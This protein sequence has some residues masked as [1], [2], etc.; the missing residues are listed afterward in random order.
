MN[1]E[2]IPLRDLHLPEAVGWW[3]P[4]SGWWLLLALAVAGL[5]LA[6]RA[7]YR[8]HRRNAPRRLALKELARLRRAYRHDGDLA[9]FVVGLSAL[10]RR[11]M[12]A[13]APRQEVAGL[14]GRAWLEWLDR[15][16]DRQPFCEGPGRSLV[17]LPYRDPARDRGGVDVDGLVE[18]VRRRLQTPLPEPA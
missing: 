15:G 12:L 7:L 17:E 1:P 13:Y 10:L 4:A 5:I 18:A 2:Q 3:P 9:R 8:A 6:A 16:L 11:A 14:T